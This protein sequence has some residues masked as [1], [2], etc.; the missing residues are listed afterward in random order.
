MNDIDP[1]KYTPM[2]QQYLQIKKDYSEYIVFF[3]LG[4]FYEMF[5]QDAHIASKELE[6]VLTG[7]DA[8]QKERVPMC[9]VPYHSA[10]MYIEKLI[11]K[12]YKIAICE[13]T[14]DA[15]AS[16]KLVKREVVRLI[17]PGTLTEEGTID[18]KSNNFIA[19]LSE[20][21]K[22]YY[23]AY[24]DLSTGQN[25]IVSTP[26]DMELVM[27]EV[28]NLDAKELV[29]P[30]D[31]NKTKLKTYTT[32][33]GLVVSFSDQTS[34]PRTY[35]NLVSDIY[36]KETLTAFGRLINYLI[37]TQKKE[38]LHLQKVEVFEAASYL[39]IDN[40]SIR[41][42]ELT[43][44][45]RT[46]SRRGSLF[47]LLDECKTAMGSRYLKQTILRPLV[48]KEHIDNRF[49]AVEA[50]N[51]DFISSEELAG[52]L[53]SVYDLERI[54]GRISFGNANG[55]DLVNL[56]RSLSVVPNVRTIIDSVG[57]PY[58]LN[59]FTHIVDFTDVH[60]LIEEAI[61]DNPP[62]TIKEGGIIKDGYSE[63]LD[64]LRDMAKNGKQWLKR[65]E[66]KERERTGISKLKIGQNRVFGYYIEVTKGQMDLVKDEFGYE[67]KQTLTNSERY[68]TTELKEKE[69]MIIGSEE[70]A[71]DLEYDLFIGI[72]NEIKAHITDLQHLARVLSEIDMLRAFS[73]VSMEN[74]YV[75]P[76]INDEKI[77]D[78][79]DGRHAVV[80]TMLDDERFV[81]NNTLMDNDTQI[82]LITGPNMSGKSTYMRQTALS[83][84]MAQMGCFIPAKEASVPIFDQIFTRI[85]ATDDLSTGKSTFMVEMLEVGYALENATDDSLII[86]DEIGRGTAT[87]DGMAL[88]QA[89]IEYVHH[90][91]KAKTLFS[92]HYHEL[93]YLED[94][95]AR[96]KNVHV[97]AREEQGTIRFMHKVEAGPTDR[98]YGIHVAKL[99]N[100]PKVLTSRAKDILAELEKNHGYN[101]IKP[102]TVDLFNYEEALTMEEQEADYEPIVR[103]LEDIDIESITPLKAMNILAD[104]IQELNNKTKGQ[105]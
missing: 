2:M 47:W 72:R 1:E 22:A 80:E 34:I 99:A 48:D 38:L 56:A 86:L 4:D 62:M 101:V 78:I 103:Q 45:V 17:T 95:L 46:Q 98:S 11:N 96:L 19:S 82:L 18:D 43:E 60:A 87:Y 31:I 63:R 25:F 42:L 93:T 64:E 68:I 66:E 59:Q 21:R 71:I 79:K 6:I 77:I 32:Q 13:Q 39:K 85:G 61:V 7:R 36:D 76:T 40:H 81:A 94:E 41:N 74:D 5:F 105:K 9:G 30:S 23:L 91:K 44:T 52:F 89:I 14:E 57:N 92:T 97:I 88:A 8:G 70:D 35:K 29:V 73:A 102:Q 12:G 28:F 27:N 50:L 15:N 26:K 51:N 53:K 10:N 16:K 69:A 37:D 84:I 3:R 58:L 90:K 75:K 33:H 54:I 65:F 24:S 55:K 100:L 67:R 83:V 20:G 104:V 49:S